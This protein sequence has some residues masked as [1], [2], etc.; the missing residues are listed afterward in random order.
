MALYDKINDP[1]RGNYA[2][3]V[4]GVSDNMAK[5]YGARHKFQI[6]SKLIT[7]GNTRYTIDTT[8]NTTNERVVGIMLTTSEEEKD[9]AQKCI[10]DS[11]LQL[12][13]DNEEIF[14]DGFDCSL[15]SSKLSAGFYDN[16]YANVNEKADGTVVKGTFVSSATMFKKPF[17][18][19]IYLICEAKPKK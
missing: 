19:K 17:T 16:V 15:I 6:I 8:T 5:M 7:A 10:N 13:I 11:T 12:S 9:E 18:L 14:P 3:E 4:T 1:M 2:D